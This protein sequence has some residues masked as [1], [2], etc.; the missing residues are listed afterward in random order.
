MKKG[1]TGIFWLK[2]NEIVV[3]LLAVLTFQAGAAFSRLKCFKSFVTRQSIH[4]L[5]DPKYQI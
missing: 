5:Q 1:D 3:E 4:L 2:L